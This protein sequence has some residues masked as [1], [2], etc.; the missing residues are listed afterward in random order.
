MLAV[1]TRL[2]GL[3]QVE[4]V[5]DIVQETL[6]CALETWKLKGLPDNPRAWLYR[7]AKNRT[8]DYLRRERNFRERVAPQAME[9]SPTDKQH[10]L[11]VYFLDSEIAD[12]QLR[13]LF[14]TCHPA[15]P[16]EGQLTLM[17][18]TLCGL[19][20]EEIAAAFMLPADSVGKRLYR[21]K[22]KIRQEKLSLEVPSGQELLRRLD[23]VLHAIY[24]LFNEGYKSATQDSVVRTE[25]CAEAIRLGSILAQHPLSNLPKTHA[26]LALL[27]FNG[28]RLHTRLNAAGEIILLPDQDRSQWNRSLIALAYEH[29]TQA[30]QGEELSAYHL[31]AAIASYHAS[32]S[33][34]EKTNWQAIYFCYNLLLNIQPSPF[35]ALNRAIA[36]GYH[37]GPAAGIEALLKIE[38]M[39]QHYL[40]HAALG[41][42]YRKTGDEA[43]AQTCYTLALHWAVL[44]R[45][46]QLIEQ[47]MG[48]P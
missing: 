28:A 25:L 24:L 12:A 30:N 18:R 13:M 20:T 5:E 3:S 21:A 45:E 15:I 2:F 44:P 41:D 22:E 34:F 17:L 47:K 6:L 39:D 7:T 23:A 16:L 11:D 32:A 42:F 29:F 8:L 1:L 10:W 33:S 43:Q 35:L 26:L 27:C 46:K 38:G 37:E 31:E 4:V 19:S 9:S 48:T 36:L 40:Y 14:A